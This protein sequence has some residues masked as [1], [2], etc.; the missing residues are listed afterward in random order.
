MKSWL[1]EHPFK[2]WKLYYHTLVPLSYMCVHLREPVA[3][4]AVPSWSHTAHGPEDMP[5]NG[6][7]CLFGALQ[8]VSSLCPGVPPT[9]SAHLLH[10]AHSPS[11]W[12]EIYQD[13][14]RREVTNHIIGAGVGVSF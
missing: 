14:W 8:E 3:L 7:C 4:P 12:M 1:S 6:C 10:L 11:T 13:Q 9:P 2:I 5:A